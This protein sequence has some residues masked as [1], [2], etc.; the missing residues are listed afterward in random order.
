MRAAVPTLTVAEIEDDME[1]VDW[2]TYRDIAAAW[3]AR[4]GFGGD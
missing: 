3:R 4:H 2:V 1:Y